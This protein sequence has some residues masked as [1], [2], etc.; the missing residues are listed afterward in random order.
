[1]KRSEVLNRLARD[2]EERIL[3][4]R[5]LDKMQLA[6]ER[7][8]PA[9]TPFLSPHERDGVERLIREMGSPRHRFT[10][11]IDQAERCVCAFLPDWMEEFPSDGEDAPMTALRA[12]WSGGTALTH[13]DFLGALM[14]MGI[15][16]EKVGDILVGQGSCDMIVLKEIAPFL[17]QSMDSA[18]RCRLSLSEVPLSEVQ[19]PPCK[20]VQ[21]R[22]TVASLRLDAVMSS[23][24]GIS[25]GKAADLI[26]AGRVTLNWRECTRP[27]KP[28]AEG[29]TIS[30]RGL[31]KCVLKEVGG[32]SKKGR[33]L[34]GME[35]YL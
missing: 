22:D 29:D 21:R 5:V 27:D 31:G 26:S 14:G 9:V 28:V 23:G 10:G 17:L 33:I 20:V 11:G 24:M 4:A 35:R 8:V 12:V 6:G 19:Q 18:G 7:G 25:R 3:L 2:G 16:R 32:E 30:C 34:I 1:M 13:R 15:T